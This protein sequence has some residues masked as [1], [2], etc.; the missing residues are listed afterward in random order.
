MIVGTVGSTPEKS[1]SEASVNLLGNLD[2]THT[3]VSTS[4]RVKVDNP[5]ADGSIFLSINGANICEISSTGL[6]VNGLK[7]QMKDKKRI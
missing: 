5:D 2:I 6:H 1:I 3:T 4:E 7:H